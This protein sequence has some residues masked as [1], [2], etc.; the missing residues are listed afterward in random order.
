MTEHS[1]ADIWIRRLFAAAV[2]GCILAQLLVFAYLGARGFPRYCNS[3]TFADMQVARRMWEQKSLFPSGWTFGNQCYVV[4]TPVLTAL[5]YGLL[6][7]IN[8]SM[9]LATEVMTVLILLSF[10]WL[11]RAAVEER[12]FRLVG[13]LTLM[14]SV[15]APYGVYSINSML[16]FSQASF[17]SCYLIT[18]FVV[19]GDYI[20]AFS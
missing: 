10:L 19:F 17:Y 13:C 14:T 18:L 15:V 8:L 7:N 20:R 3:D 12:L 9:V 1:R 6:G 2:V 11:L 4:A 5:F 16:F